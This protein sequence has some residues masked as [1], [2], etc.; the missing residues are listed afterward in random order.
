MVCRDLEKQRQNWRYRF[1]IF[2]KEEMVKSVRVDEFSEGTDQK[3]KR[4]EIRSSNSAICQPW[5]EGG[6]EPG[7][8]TKPKGRRK[9]FCGTQRRCKLTV[10]CYK[11]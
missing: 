10:S 9:M 4:P 6:G 1:G 2:H 8:D 7:Q 3:Q 11:W 5:G